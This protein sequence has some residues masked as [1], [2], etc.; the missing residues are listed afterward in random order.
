MCLHCGAEKVEGLKA[1]DKCGA[2]YD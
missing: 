2:E 1:C